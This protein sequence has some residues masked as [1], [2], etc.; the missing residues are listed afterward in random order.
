MKKI[1]ILILITLIAFSGKSNADTI[2]T[3]VKVFA[4]KQTLATLAIPRWK[5]FMSPSDPDYLRFSFANWGTPATHMVYSN[6]GGATWN[7]ANALLSGELTVDYHISAAGDNSGNFYATMPITNSIGFRKVNFPAQQSSDMDPLR[8]VIT[9]GGSNPRSNVMIQPNNQR[10]WVFTRASTIP[11]ENVRYHYSDNGGQS[12]TSG[13][14]DATHADEVRIGSMPY[15]NG[16][17]AL[18]V[19][20]MSSTPP[21][22]YKYYM[23]NGSQFVAEDDAVIY[24]GP[25][26]LMRAFTHNVTD[27]TRMHL[28]FGLDT[29]LHHYW[30]EYNNGQGTWNSQIIDT[31]PYNTGSI[32]WET[33]SCVRGSDFFVFYSKN[34]NSSATSS[35]IYYNKWSG[36]TQ[37]WA[38]PQVISTHPENTD[39]HHPNSAMQVPVTS[40]YI[41]VWWYSHLG[42]SNEQIYFNKIVVDSTVQSVSRGEIDRKIK[43][44][45]EGTASEQEVLDLINMYNSQ[46]P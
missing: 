44:F 18:V 35:E 4:A 43:D 15:I 14:A 8:T 22:G 38:T 7:S 36:A 40:D 23:W 2:G 13:I 41:P 19:A 33:S 12:W 5:G 32:D 1:T 17:P 11:S 30:K 39:N 37:S 34:T 16:N 29:E 3:P 46:N 24:S 45:K 28:V 6:D 42:S 25:L 31:S 9:V 20:Y 27:G 10:I 26:G 21:Q